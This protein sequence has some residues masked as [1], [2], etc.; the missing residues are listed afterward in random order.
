M[1]E[2]T[3]E[4]KWVNGDHTAKSKNLS[5]LKEEKK[6]S[7]FGVMKCMSFTIRKGSRILSKQRKVR[8]DSKTWSSRSYNKKKLQFFFSINYWD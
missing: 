4:G 5:P 8:K 3:K 1:E 7:V 2:E 6:Q